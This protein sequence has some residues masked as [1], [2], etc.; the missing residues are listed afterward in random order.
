[1]K[2]ALTVIGCC[3]LLLSSAATRAVAQAPQPDA[4]DLAHRLA[5]VEAQ[6]NV[7]LGWHTASEAARAALADELAKAQA[8]I[9]QL[10]LERAPAKESP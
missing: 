5:V 6:R 3:V 2:R 1:M 10:E 8:R 9:R 4:T 7:I